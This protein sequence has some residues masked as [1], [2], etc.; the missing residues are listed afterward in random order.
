MK[1]LSELLWFPIPYFCFVRE[2]HLRTKD[3]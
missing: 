2:G 1:S 3:I